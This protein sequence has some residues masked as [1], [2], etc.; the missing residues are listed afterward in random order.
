MKQVTQTEAKQILLSVLQD[1]KKI[2]EENGFRYTL[3]YGTLLGAVR[4]RGFIPWDDDLDI[5]MPRPDYQRFVEYCRTHETPFALKCIETD[6][7]YGYLFAKA[8]DRGTVLV[9]HHGNRH[10]VDFGLYVDIFPI[11]GLGDS[12]ADAQRA[13]RSMR[14]E[15]ELLVAAQWQH[16]F[17]STTNPWYYEPIRL[18]FF[19]VSRF[20]S[21]EKIIKRVTRKYSEIDVEHAKYV[22]IMCGAY[23]NREVMEHDTYMEFCDAEFEEI[24]VRVLK[25]SDTYLKTIY[26][27]YMTLPP[28]EKRVARHSFSVYFKED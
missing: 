9:E 2:C 25:N 24:D 1:I 22:G 26:K 8:C 27:D 14:F 7:R 6:P 17:K 11:D 20:V 16:F 13:L 15:R 10:G 12:P 5:A 3:I 21:H 4:H 23:R 19:L 18:F 28:E